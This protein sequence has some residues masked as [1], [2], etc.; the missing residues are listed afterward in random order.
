MKNIGIE[1][2]A[3]NTYEKLKFEI[4]NMDIRPGSILTENDISSKYDISRST[5]RS[6]FQQLK[7]D[8]LITAIPYKLSYVSQLNMNRILE[9]I[10][11]RIAIESTVMRDFI[12]AYNVEDIKKLEQ[13]IED[14]NKAMIQNEFIKFS[15]LDSDFHKIMF[16]SIDKLEVWQILQKAELS[17]VR[18]KTLDLITVGNTNDML[19]DHK[20]L[21]KIIKDRNLDEIEVAYKKH[22]Y[23]GIRR[24][25]DSVFSN[26]SDYFTD[27]TDEKC[28]RNIDELLSEVYD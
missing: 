22:L 13:N 6:V 19:E 18:F 15:K 20:I 25:R 16:E 23:S 14:Q 10:Y 3:D 9:V 28:L 8:E 17:Y 7:S 4:L 1:T 24:L 12:K 27:D 2:L 11:M 21:L 5:V 26:F